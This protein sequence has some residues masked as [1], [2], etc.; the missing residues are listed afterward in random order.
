MT[1]TRSLPIATL[2]FALLILNA[3]PASAHHPAI[4]GI[5]VCDLTDETWS[6]NWT[7]TPDAVRGKEWKITD[8]GDVFPENVWQPDSEPFTGTQEDVE[9]GTH[10][11]TI[12]ASWRPYGP[13]NVSRSGTVTVDGPCQR[14]AQL[15]PVIEET[16]SVVVDCDTETVTTT[17][18]TTTTE[19]VWNGE[20]WVL[21]EP[22]TV[23]S[24][25]DR[26]ADAQECPP[27]S[28]EPPTTTPPV[29][30]PPVVTEPPVVSP[31]D[32][33]AAQATPSA[34]HRPMLP[35][36]GSEGWL[37]VAGAGLV[38]VG[39]GVVWLTRRREPS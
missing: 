22:V 16:S 5:A 30:E 10:T 35:A 28:T 34:V 24:T 9:P 36:T 11:L 1:R 18:S 7:A 31:P 2:I 26:P 12:S 38:A 14:P 37:A 25:T 23:E 17:T 6:I 8:G 19:Y 13:R 29:A 32:P 27:P 21:G 15:E 4:T 20:E 33:P 39:A 3:G